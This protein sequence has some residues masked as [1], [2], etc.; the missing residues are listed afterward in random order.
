MSKPLLY[1]IGKSDACRHAVQLLQSSGIPIIRH[2]SP[3]VTHLLLDIRPGEDRNLS[4][5]LSMLPPSITV[6]GG[7]LQLPEY[8]VWDFLKDEGYLARNAA[9]TAHCA[10]KL[11]LQQLQTTLP[12]TK[13]LILGWG[14]IG[15]CLG[16]LLKDL[17]CPVTVYARKEAD[18][19]MLCALGYSTQSTCF[20]A[21]FD[22]VFNTIPAAIVPEEALLPCP[23]LI[24]IDLASTPGIPGNSG[25][26][27]R[28]L[29]GKLAPVS[30]GRLIANTVLQ[31]IKEET[32]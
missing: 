12:D 14:R 1:P 30:S 20:P 3:E 23:D 18:R 32:P 15:K 11:A 26:S 7:N 4:Y 27:A 17:G 5:T 9:I 13:V 29:P 10:L 8:R 25:I 24:K 22:L 6:I 16:K 21:G 31:Y 2:P 28:G 19:A